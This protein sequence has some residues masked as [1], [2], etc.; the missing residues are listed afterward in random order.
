MIMCVPSAG[1]CVFLIFPLCDVG[2][3]KHAGVVPAQRH[4]PGGGGVQSHR[5]RLPPGHHGLHV[6]RYAPHFHTDCSA[7]VVWKENQHG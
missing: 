5:Q 7:L 3:R 6:S 1:A 2:D 4:G